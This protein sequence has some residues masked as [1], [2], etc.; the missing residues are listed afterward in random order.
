MN[1]IVTPGT[2]RGTVE[3]PA[4][5]SIA[6]RALIAAALANRPTQLRLNA[7][8]EDLTATAGGLNALGAQI[9]RTDD[10]F[11][12][13]PIA[14][15]NSGEIDCWESGSTLRFLLPVAAALGSEATFLGRGRLPDR[16]HDL[17][18]N[19]MAEHGVS[20]DSSRLPL[21][22][23]GRL[24][25]GLYELPGNVSSQYIT[26]LLLAL[27]LCAEDSEIRL[28]TK[29]ESAPY[30]ALTLDVLN[31]FGIRVEPT[32]HG[33]RIPGGQHYRSPGDFTVEGDWSSAAFWKAANALGSDITC[34][35]LN[36]SSAQGDRAI[37]GHLAALGG[38]IDVS[39]CP[40]LVP[41][42]AV[43]AAGHSGTTRLTN[44]ARLRLKESD[45]LATVAALLRSLGGSVEE[46]ADMLIIHGGT[47]LHGGTVDGC[48]DHRI[49]MAAVIAATM[50][51]GPVTVLGAQAIRKSY[52]GFIDDFIALGGKLHVESDR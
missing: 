51:S 24:R 15:P 20:S 18:L 13:Q 19:A 4:S 27:P 37:V 1:V 52:P 35:G 6:H 16:P 28:T 10:G 26:G 39:E 12:V 42:L 29:L 44:A 3:I 34:V 7:L 2:L 25:G 31:A 14:A 46:G 21:R 50:A 47:P 32:G 17:L 49:V 48:G 11:S 8:N 38:D 33:W 40:D 22:L 41:A 9:V 23:S 30:V 36:E 43:A 45:R 5:K